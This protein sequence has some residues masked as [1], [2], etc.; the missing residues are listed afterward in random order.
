[1]LIGLLL[2]VAGHSAGHD[3]CSKDTIVERIQHSRAT[4]FDG[5][6]VPVCRELPVQPLRSSVVNNTHCREQHTSLSD[7]EQRTKIPFNGCPRRRQARLNLFLLL[8]GNELL[9]FQS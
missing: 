8:H 4:E 2:D 7:P 5:Q 9:Y 3:G 1:M 6:G